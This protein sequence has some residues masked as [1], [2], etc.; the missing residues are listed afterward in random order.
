MIISDQV[1]D[2]LESSDQ[3]T[4]ELESSDQVTESGTHEYSVSVTLVE[5]DA[6]K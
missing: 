6:L 3:V 4:D 2:E 1:T 5:L